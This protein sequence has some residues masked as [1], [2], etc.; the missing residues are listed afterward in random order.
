MKIDDLYKIM[1]DSDGDLESEDS[2]NDIDSDDDQTYIS[3]GKVR[4][5]FVEN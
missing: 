5:N 2:D 4:S 3:G 1:N